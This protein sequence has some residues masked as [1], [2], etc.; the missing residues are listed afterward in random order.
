MTPTDT[1]TRVDGQPW[2][3]VS[4][5][6]EVRHTAQGKFES[7]GGIGILIGGSS[8]RD[9]VAYGMSKNGELKAIINDVRF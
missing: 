3:I 5:L 2:K 4:L 8:K 7:G 6:R 9:C 1:S